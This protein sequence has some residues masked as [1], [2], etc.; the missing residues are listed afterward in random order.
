MTEPLTFIDLKT[1]GS[2]EFEDEIIEF[3]AARLE[4]GKVTERFSE[5]ARAD[6]PLP[7]H[8][9]KRTGITEEDLRDKPKSRTV[10]G[11]FMDFIGKGVLVT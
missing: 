10:L 3:G 11:D 7:L 8:V 5:L 1:T 2:N 4:A 6:G 9:T